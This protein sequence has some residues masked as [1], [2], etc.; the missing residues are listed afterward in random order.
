MLLAQR[1][2]SQQRNLASVRHA[3]QHRIVAVRE[4]AARNCRI[5]YRQRRAADVRCASQNGDGSS[6]DSGADSGAEAPPPSALSAYDDR[7]DSYMQDRCGSVSRIMA[8]PPS[9]R[10][11]AKGA[12]EGI[13]GLQ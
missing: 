7:C 1:L 8:R 3:A 9:D 6:K 10:F 12:Q 13:V 2:G 11:A 5:A 4:I